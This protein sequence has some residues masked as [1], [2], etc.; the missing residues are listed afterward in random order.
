M[1]ITHLFRPFFYT[2]VLLGLLGLGV[3]GKVNNKFRLDGLN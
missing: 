1:S 3:A 2:D